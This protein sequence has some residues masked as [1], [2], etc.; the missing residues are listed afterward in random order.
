MSRESLSG[1][2]I[3]AAASTQIKLFHSHDVPQGGSS[4]EAGAFPKSFPF[5]LCG[6]NA[7]PDLAVISLGVTVDPAV[8][9]G[10]GSRLA[11]PWKKIYPTL[12]DPR[13]RYLVA[14][15]RAL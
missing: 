14:K 4:T 5:H 13:V 12:D 9:G 11:L 15:N 1:N 7:S 3:D 6:K 10:I 2:E 8:I